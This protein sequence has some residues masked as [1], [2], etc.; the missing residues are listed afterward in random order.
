MSMEGKRIINGTFGTVILDGEEVA[1]TT[2]LQ[3]KISYKFADINRAGEL[4]TD[5]KMIS[6][7]G[8]GSLK[9]YKVNSRM[10]MRIGE[11][12]KEGKD[13]RFTITSRLADPDAFGSETIILKNVLFT[14]LTLV[15]WTNAK[16]ATI[17]APFAFTKYDL[18][19]SIDP[20]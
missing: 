1:E 11:L 18:I 15:D 2:G 9:M 17:E 8:T 4:A 13:V 20:Q 16:E 12:L 14:D 3:A 19:D 10:A 5:K 7:D 6:Y